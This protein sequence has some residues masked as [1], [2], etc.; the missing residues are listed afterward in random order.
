[1]PARAWSFAVVRSTVRALLSAVLVGAVCAG[2]GLTHEAQAQRPFQT[3]DPLYQGEQAQRTFYDG[4]AVSALIDY[5]PTGLLQ[6]SSSTG[7]GQRSAVS[8]AGRVDY[9]LLPQVDVAAIVDLSGG[10]GTGPVALR[11]LIVK[12]FWTNEGT[13]YAVRIAVDPASEGGLGFRQTDVAFLSSS[14]LT[15]LVSTDFA[16]GL[17][18]VRAGVN[19]ELLDDTGTFD[20]TMALL[21]D[22]DRIRVIGTEMHVYWGVNFHYDLA[23][24]NVAVALLAEGAT[25]RYVET[26]AAQNLP[27]AFEGAENRV[28]SGIGWLQLGL[29]FD[30]PSFQL[31]PHV[32]LPLVVWGD[33]QGESVRSGPR[34]NKVRVGL[35]IMLR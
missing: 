14:D 17:R 11:W 10:I 8:L 18:R 25:Y 5:R 1:M 22:G 2:A 26:D 24:S 32:A 19:A 27:G 30:R 35:N 20:N 23:G 16:I 29:D 9:A 6:S 15:P 28:R 33:V 7:V 3:L 21:L 4:L 13:D 34:P 31:S 12:P